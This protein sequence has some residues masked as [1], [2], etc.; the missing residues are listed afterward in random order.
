MK[1]STRLIEFGMITVVGLACQGSFSEAA[2]AQPAAPT[3]TQTKTPGTQVSWRGNLLIEKDTFNYLEPK[4]FAQTGKV[5]T[6]TVG[7]WEVVNT[8]SENPELPY[9]KEVGIRPD[10]VEI[11]VQCN[12]PAYRNVAAK[13]YHTYA[14]YVPIERLMGMK[15]TAIVGPHGDPK[16]VKGVLTEQTPDGEIAGTA[17]RWIG[18]SGIGKNIVFDLNPKGLTSYYVSNCD[19]HS[20]W[21]VR[22]V[23]NYV[24][25]SI[26]VSARDWGGVLSS[27]AIIFEAS[28]DD[29][30]NYHTGNPYWYFYQIP[31]TQNFIFGEYADDK[32]YVSIKSSLYDVN[33]G[34]GWVSTEGLRDYSEAIPSFAYTATMGSMDSEFISKIEKP[35]LYA[36]RVFSSNITADECGPF[37]VISNGEMKARDQKVEGVK[38]KTITYLQ[39]LPA[40]VFRLKV[41]GSWIISGISLQMVIHENAD[42]SFNRGAWLVPEVFEPTPVLSSKFYRNPPEYKVA[43]SE[44]T[45]PPKKL[46]EPKSIKGFSNLETSLPATD[47]P[48]M[49]W[50]YDGFI[51]G[52]GQDNNGTFLEYDTPEKITRRLKEMK[53]RGV[54]IVM[55]NGYLARHCFEGQLPRV[56]K[57]VKEIVRIAHSLDMKVI[58]HRELT[59]LWYMETSLRYMSEHLDWCQR[60][61]DDDTLF[62]GLCPLEPGHR[63]EYFANIKAYIADTGIDGVMIDEVAFHSIM[64]CGCAHCREQFTKDTGLVLPIGKN[65]KMI[66]NKGSL[67]HK[68]WMEWRQKAMGDWWVEFRKEAADNRQDFCIMGYVCDVGLW[69][70]FDFNYA[71]DLFSMARSNDFVGTE[72]WLGNRM[73]NY[74]FVYADRRYFNVFRHEGGYPVFGLVYHSNDEYFAYFGWAM[75]NMLGQSTW[76]PTEVSASPN[77]PDFL[78]WPDNMNKQFAKEM[79]DVAIIFSEKSRNWT[80][81]GVPAK[82]GIGI[83]QIL[84]DNH[85]QHVILTERSLKNADDLKKFRAVILP[86]TCCMSDAEIQVIR[87]YVTQGGHVYITG[88]AGLLDAYGTARAEWGFADLVGCDVSQ[89]VTWPAGTQVE[90]MDGVSAICFQP[91]LQ[92]KLRPK[93]TTTKVLLNATNKNGRVLGPAGVTNTIGKG[94]ITYS[95]VQMGTANYQTV[96]RDKWEYELNRPLAEIFMTTFREALGGKLLNFEVIQI[97]SQMI[98][99]QWMQKIDGVDCTLIHLLNATGVRMKKGD[100]VVYKKTMPAFPALDKDVI[101]EIELPS[102]SQAYVTSPD[103]KGHKAARVEKVSDGRYRVTVPKEA[104]QAYAVVLLK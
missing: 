56:Q 54:N 29:Y 49:A 82:D 64:T 88:D 33:K 25:F 87:E 63:K 9:R 90:G 48:K 81:S 44:V 18:F 41:T 30:L 86:S 14:F 99:S 12:L 24:V 23:G 60:T 39:W 74:R 8:T 77:T 104:I 47:D 55:L 80:P 37:S 2:T 76:D 4:T 96:Y 45:L 75:N 15:W 51:G 16:T 85:I 46:V 21:N 67:L 83:S 28:P 13:G 78:K 31:I 62:Q 100:K 66:N 42:Y 17:A 102:I 20:P 43:I 11:T 97:P 59:I 38:Y 34:Y 36:V 5:Q 71:Y 50:R 73:D 32:A 101:F 57:K 52:M 103:Y 91:M 84:S 92:I 94:T 95:C 40:G 22:R 6:A 58:D 3:F 98:S 69:S 68:A 70:E 35:G 27:K 26:S 19:L 89:D 10:R 53:A 72:I 65:S 61:I 79:G 93:S 1:W 7:E